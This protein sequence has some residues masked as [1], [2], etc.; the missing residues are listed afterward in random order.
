MNNIEKIRGGFCLED[1]CWSAGEPLQKCLEWY[2]PH[3]SIREHFS[4]AE[5]KY[6]TRAHSREESSPCAV[7]NHGEKAATSLPQE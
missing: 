2:S 7:G 4:K 3:A 6:Q 5:V 1:C